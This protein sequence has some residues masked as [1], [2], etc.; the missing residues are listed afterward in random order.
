MAEI[1]LINQIQCL[2][3]PIFNRWL[4]RDK[5]KGNCLQSDIKNISFIKNVLFFFK[6]NILENI[7]SRTS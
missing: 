3:R 1:Q 7:F 5:R 6:K 4:V 2:Y